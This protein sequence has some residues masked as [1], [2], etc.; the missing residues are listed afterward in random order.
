MIPS[1]QLMQRDLYLK[2]L[3]AHIDGR[4]EDAMSLYDQSL[5][6]AGSKA[7]NLVTL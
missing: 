4:K 7:S 2:G 1:E 3:Q 6:E 5:H